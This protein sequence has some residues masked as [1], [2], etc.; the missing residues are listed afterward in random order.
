MDIVLS[1]KANDGTMAGRIVVNVVMT[2][3]GIDLVN[4]TR[5]GIQY[6]H[7]GSQRIYRITKYH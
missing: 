4:G 2:V 6:A 7:A 5:E 1:I 3:N